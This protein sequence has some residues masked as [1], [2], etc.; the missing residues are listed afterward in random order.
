MYDDGGIYFPKLCADR[1]KFQV[2]S[3][4]LIGAYLCHGDIYFS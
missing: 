3:V 1:V 4:G 2:E